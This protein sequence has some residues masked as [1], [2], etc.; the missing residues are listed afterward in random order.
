ML[1]ANVLSTSTSRPG[2]DYPVKTPLPE[3][4]LQ[5]WEFGGTALQDPND[6]LLVKVWRAFLVIDDET[7]VGSI[8]VEAPDVSPIFVLDGLGITDVDLAFDQNMNLFLCFTQLG[9][10]KYYWFDSTAGGYVT[11]SLPAGCRSPR[12]CLDDHRAFNTVNSDVVLGYINPLN[13]LCIRYQRDRYLV[14]YVLAG[15]FPE[16]L[17]YVGMNKEFRV[18]FGLGFA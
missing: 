14:E 2:F 16:S 11:D 10:A 12:C 5:G 3:D 15:A 4:L 13:E 8:F 17:I 9:I 7:N 6:G 18:Q 1:P